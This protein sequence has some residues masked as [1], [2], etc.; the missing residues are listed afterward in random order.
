LEFLLQVLDELDDAAM[1]VRHAWPRFVLGI[2]LLG[3]VA[4]GFVTLT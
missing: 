3:V 4:A 2:I 1:A